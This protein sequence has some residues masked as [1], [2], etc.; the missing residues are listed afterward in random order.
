MQMNDNPHSELDASTRFHPDTGR[1]LKKG[2]AIF[3]AILV[4]A[5]ILVR[6]D[7]FFKDRAVAN[8]AEQTSSAPHVVDV[9]EAVPVGTVQ[10]LSLP[11][12]TSAWH[13]STIYAR[14][15]GYVGKWLVDI[16]DP[17]HRG[18]VMASIETPDLD[19]Q[20]A[21]ARAQ[22]Q[23]AQAQVL[24]RR[25]QA[26]FAKSTYDRWRD[27]PQGVVSE[28][29]RE[30]K[31]ADY[32]S[33]AAN[34]ESA[35]ADVTL[36]RSRVNQYA[37]MSEF[38]QVTAPYDG[39]VSQRDIDIGN[40]VTAGSTNSTTPLYVMTQN[41]PMRVFVDVPQSAAA[42]LMEGSIPVDVQ[43]P[44]NEG[45]TFTGSV[46]RTAQAINQQARTLR[47]E[48]DIPNA[49][50]S[51]VPGMY[52]KVGFNLQPKGLVQIPAAALIFRAGGP[53]VACVDKSSHVTFRNVTIARDDG[54]AVEL[55]A[56]ASPGDELVLNASSQ[57]GN[58]DTVQV[59]HEA[60]HKEPPRDQQQAATT[61]AAPAE[62]KATPTPPTA[63]R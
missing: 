24:V 61:R 23:A 26:E 38:K 31:H 60:P 10:R 55:G 45:R 9:I 57:I 58:G 63:K 11:G 35:E 2:A 5:F 6:I 36:D 32:D 39:V 33:A 16:G 53:Q 44:G 28:Q 8:S 20:L 14:V 48:I 12:Q 37:A 29:E 42:D 34:L 7:R 62:A 52:V 49:Q 40:L 22:L 54:N 47:V 18:Q 46:T 59:N 56:G 13:S 41:D 50:Q 43:V 19:A 1:R 15:N 27:S 30:Q 25:A 17:V 51:L 4:A 3:A 21:G